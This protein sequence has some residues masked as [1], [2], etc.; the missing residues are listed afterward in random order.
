[1]TDEIIAYKG[2]N[3]DLKCRNF[4]YEVGKTYK[5]HGKVSIC[6][7]GFHACE[8]PM[9]VWSYYNLVDSRYA[10]VSLKKPVKNHDGDSKIASAEITIKAELSLPEFI[11]HAVNYI[12]DLCKQN[13]GNESSGD[14][15]QIGSSGDSAKIG[16]SGHSAKIDSEGDKAIIACAGLSSKVKG[17]DGC[18]IALPYRD[19]N[20]QYR[21][22]TCVVGENGI[23][24][25]I[26]Y[27]VNEQ[28]EFIED[29]T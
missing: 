20:D 27:L 22:A 7:S 25:D 4:Q 28:G 6:N 24:P 29:E 10:L 11:T 26:Y 13:P 14:S 18:A 19:D 5:H 9:D 2:F 12:I 3:E 23:K 15:A 17:K 16:S 8:N 1:M 21:F